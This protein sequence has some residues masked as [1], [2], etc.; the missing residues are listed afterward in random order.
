MEGASAPLWAVSTVEKIAYWAEWDWSDQD[1]ECDA[2]I[3][4]GNEY[5]DDQDAIWLQGRKK[6]N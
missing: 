2:L 5:H 6:P 4:G 1:G 3:V